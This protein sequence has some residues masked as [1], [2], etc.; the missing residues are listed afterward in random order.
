MKKLLILLALAV[1]TLSAAAQIVQTESRLTYIQEEHKEKITYPYNFFIKAGGGV[2]ICSD[3]G[4]TGGAYNV[5]FGYQR[6]VNAHGLYWGAQ[7]GIATFRNVVEDY[8]SVDGNSHR[9]YFGES[10]PAIYG[11]FMLG[12]KKPVGA[13]NVFDCHLGATYQASFGRLTEY[14]RTSKYDWESSVDHYTFESFYGGPRWE[15]GLGIWFNRVLVELEYAGFKPV[16]DATWLAL[17][18]S[19]LVNVGYRF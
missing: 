1:A 18:N 9:T 15:L 10:H 17:N 16:H 4:E 14:I 13:K 8:Y 6:T 11:G 19:I 7:I 2:V 12:L 5:A 3:G